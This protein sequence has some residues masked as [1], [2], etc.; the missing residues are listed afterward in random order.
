MPHSSDG[1]NNGSPTA[2][3][4]SI[5]CG[6]AKAIEK[7]EELKFAPFLFRANREGS[8]GVNRVGLDWWVH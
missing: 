2:L 7:V 8:K 6:L 3:K 1:F 4:T 5:S